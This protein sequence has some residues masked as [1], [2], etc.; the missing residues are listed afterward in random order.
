MK[1]NWSE[2]GINTL[3]ARIILLTLVSLV[4]TI[5]ILFFYQNYNR[6]QSL[7]ASEK[8]K[9]MEMS[10]KYEGQL[11]KKITSF[12]N[13]IDNFSRFYLATE[14]DST[15]SLT[16]SQIVSLLGGI[17]ER[18]D[19][20][21]GV[22]TIWEPRAFDSPNSAYTAQLGHDQTGNFV[23][24]WHI[25]N[26]QKHVLEPYST[27]YVEDF[28]T[29][30]RENLTTY[31]DV[32]TEFPYNDDIQSVI[33]ISKPLVH[34]GNF[35]GVVFAQYPLASFNNF[36]EEVA[37]DNTVLDATLF[38]HNGLILKKTGSPELTGKEGSTI[39]NNFQSELENIQNAQANLEE[40][41]DRLEARVPVNIPGTDQRWQ[42]RV[43]R[44][45][46]TILE[47]AYYDP[48]ALILVIIL[49][50]V[51]AASEFYVLKKLFAPLNE[52]ANTAGVLAQGNT[53]VNQR[54]IKRGR[55][56]E[57]L[58]HAFVTLINYLQNLTQF[59]QEIGK[60]NYKAEYR[61]KSD[62]DDLGS[63]LIKLRENF[64]QAQNKE[65]ERKHE[66]EKRNWIN[67]GLAKFN[68]ILHRRYD[69]LE[70]LAYN[71]IKELVD[72]V[73][74]NQGGLFLYQS[75]E[76]DESGEEKGESYLELMAAI[77][78]DERK[79]MKKTVNLGE[80]L[81][82]TCAVEQKTIY[83]TDI[84]E[85]YIEI[86]SGLGDA[87]PTN[88]V[89]IPLVVKKEL[90]GVV[91][92]ASFYAIPEYKREFLERLADSMATTLSASQ[93]NERTAK[94]L[95]KSKKQAEEMAAQEEEM[96][97]NLEELTATQEDL[98]KK[99]T[100]LEAVNR[101]SDIAFQKAEFNTSAY[102]TY[103]NDNFA[104]VMGYEKNELE[105]KHHHKLLDKTK[106]EE[107]DTMWNTILQGND[108]HG[109]MKWI[110]KSGDFV[111]NISTYAPVM[112]KNNEIE[113]IICMSYDIS[114]VK[115]LEEKINSIE[116]QLNDCT[117]EKQK[118][119]N[120]YQE[121]DNQYKVTLN[122][123]RKENDNLKEEL[124]NFGKNN[125]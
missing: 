35:L 59:A 112:D 113:K 21:V 88:L 77:A 78:Y 64:E 67:V 3:F 47:N 17:I 13:V 83:M 109:Q 66:D 2:S 4:I 86:T 62:Q 40:S 20:V 99:Q 12:T 30:A 96:R 101:L 7:M 55:E 58:S 70:E 119:E 124:N 89:L 46:Q 5:I 10:K 63:T 102:F 65:E 42:L 6:K 105:G 44:S 75:E 25:S 18:H 28:Y 123:L 53:D 108:Y 15:Q 122:N 8:A 76:K 57:K 45:K 93:V 115:D 14:N 81:V 34:K 92:L 29:E 118:L 106:F 91:E 71:I 103:I 85:D 97:Q 50:V 36:F 107:F 23:P 94:L 22:G 27:Y 37:A 73:D 26:S 114:R 16:R 48:G 54:V 33:M 110:R 49:L 95:E 1:S 79:Y 32:V 74:A 43:A 80:G 87:P 41:N 52:L 38:S 82:G 19:N 117:G 125:V 31:I 51:I 11:E 24:Y 98:E 72:Y 116:K 60:G 9:L 121:L 90:Y 69:N 68:E 84:P 39:L 56:L 100:E 61:K 111:W 104:K 120:D